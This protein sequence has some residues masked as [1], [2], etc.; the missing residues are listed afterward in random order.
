MYMRI[1]GKLDPEETHSAICRGEVD[2]HLKIDLLHDLV[3]SLL[4]I[5]YRHH[6]KGDI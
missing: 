5:S 2:D 1:D 3:E 4:G 6:R